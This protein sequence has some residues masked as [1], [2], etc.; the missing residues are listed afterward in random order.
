MKTS[1][2]YSTKH[3]HWIDESD[4][5]NVAKKRK[6]SAISF[7]VAVA[8]VIATHLAVIGGIYAYTFPKP[9]MDSVKTPTDTTVQGPAGPKSDALARNE[10][11]QP[12]VKPRVVAIPAP[13]AKNEIASKPS[14]NPTVALAEKPKNKPASSNVLAVAQKPSAPLGDASDETKRKAFLATRSSKSGVEQRRD[15]E[16]STFAP[17]VAVPAAEIAATLPANVSH[18]TASARI[19]FPVP[20][21]EKQAQNTTP[22]SEYTLAAGDNLYLVARKLGVSFNDL[23]RENGINDPRQLRIGQILKVPAIAAL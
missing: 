12:E 22:V 3:P 1:T 14:A 15:V 18:P 7:S 13:P 6:R 10:W 9:R 20:Q 21:A 16:P 17:K 5:P 2:T 23:A 19:A 4:Y 11:P 8:I